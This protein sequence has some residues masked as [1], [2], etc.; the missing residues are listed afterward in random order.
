MTESPVVVTSNSTNADCSTLSTPIQCCSETEVPPATS[1]LVT[2]T[3]KMVERNGGQRELVI[4][5]E[6]SVLLNLHF[7]DSELI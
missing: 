5:K 2:I 1:E 4:G 7:S 3:H 6:I